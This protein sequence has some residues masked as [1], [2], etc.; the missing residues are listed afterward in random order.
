MVARYPWPLRLFIAT[1]VI[2][3]VARSAFNIGMHH[4]PWRVQLEMHTVPLPLPSRAERAQ[5]TAGD[6][7]R[8]RSLAERWVASASSVLRFFQPWPTARTAAHLEHTGDWLRYVAVWSHTRLEFLGRIVG[9][10]ER[11][12]MY[13]PSVGTSRKVVR[14][15]LHF[16][17]GATVELRCLAEPQDLS[18]FLRPFAQRR[19]Q[20]D[21]NL[22]NLAEVRLGWSRWLARTHAVNVGG[23]PLT[24][25]ELHFVKHALAPPSEDARAFWSREN[26]RPIVEPPFFRFDVAT[27]TGSS[28]TSTEETNASD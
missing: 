24:R 5:I 6:S 1:S 13:S 11:W 10:D 25:I 2:G 20:H 3:I 23:S 19:L 17:D 14:A 7:P 21:V 18:R 4:M 27:D 22:G 12:T 9:V 15:V 16:H 26:A 8:Y 28:L